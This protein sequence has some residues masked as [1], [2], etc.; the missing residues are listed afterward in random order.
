[1][2]QCIENNSWQHF[3]CNIPPSLHDV[4]D[5][6][7]VWQ[8]AHYLTLLGKAGVF[9]WKGKGALWPKPACSCMSSLGSRY[10][11]IFKDRSPTA[12]S[13][14]W[15]VRTLPMVNEGDAVAWKESKPRSPLSPPTLYLHFLDSPLRQEGKSTPASRLWREYPVARQWAAQTWKSWHQGRNNAASAHKLSLKL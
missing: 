2:L 3:Q 13:G 7:H 1:M 15:H 9:P 5:P 4:P 12:R 14:W 8:A 10:S 6:L 11:E